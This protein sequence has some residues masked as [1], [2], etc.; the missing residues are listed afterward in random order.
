MGAGDIMSSAN[1]LAKWL[2]V[3]EGGSILTDESIEAMST[4]YSTENDMYEYG[5]GWFISKDG[6]Y[7]GGNLSEFS[8]F[9]FT[10]PDK[11]YSIIILSNENSGTLADFGTAIRYE[12]F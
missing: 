2:K 9:L 8:S 3:F 10:S 12:L 1:D 4:S 5:Y 7:H 6:I 11:K